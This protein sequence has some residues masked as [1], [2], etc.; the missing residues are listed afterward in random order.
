MAFEFDRIPDRL[1]EQVDKVRD[2]TAEAVGSD[3]VSILRELGKLGRA[4]DGVEDHIADRLDAFDG[5]LEDLAERV[6]DFESGG[7]NATTWPRRLFWVAVGAGIG[8]G[9]GYLNDPDRGQAR[10]E[11]IVDTAS[12][13]AREVGQEISTRAGDVKAQ[14]E[15]SAQ[16]VTSQAKSSAQD[17]ADE[18]SAAA[19]DVRDQVE[20]SSQAIADEARPND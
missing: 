8:V 18:A 1:T 10:R 5:T 12:S 6:S 16:R 20:T 4:L 11:Q 19:D 2:R 15:V 3:G 14:A 9:I 17:V 7:D 13:R